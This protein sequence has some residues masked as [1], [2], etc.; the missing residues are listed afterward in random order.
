MLLVRQVQINN[1]QCHK[2]KSLQGNNQDVKQSPAQLQDT[3]KK[4]HGNTAAVHQGDKDKDHFTR[5][6]IAE[7]SQ[8]Q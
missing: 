4:S 5:I 8:C 7:Q 1:S 2:D 6:H 3:T